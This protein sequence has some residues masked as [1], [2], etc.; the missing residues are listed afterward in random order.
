MEYPNV[1]RT[2]GAVLSSGRASIVEVTDSLGLEDV[3]DL[4]EVVVVDAHNARVLQKVR[5][6]EQAR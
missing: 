2:I 3:Y 1:P 6:A 4:L 5:E